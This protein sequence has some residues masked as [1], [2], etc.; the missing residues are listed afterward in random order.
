MFADH[1]LSFYLILWKRHGH[2]SELLSP[3]SGQFI[4][5]KQ[6]GAMSHSNTALPGPAQFLSPFNTIRNDSTLIAEPS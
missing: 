3:Y 4:K 6:L 5:Q 2:V 1:L